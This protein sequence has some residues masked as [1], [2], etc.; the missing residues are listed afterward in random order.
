[1]HLVVL[2]AIAAL[3]PSPD[4]PVRDCIIDGHEMRCVVMNA[5]DGPVAVPYRGAAIM[6]RSAPI[7][8]SI[9]ES[10]RFR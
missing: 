9:E 8:R 10:R 1:L 3:T 4:R 2:A 5:P 6:E 7:M